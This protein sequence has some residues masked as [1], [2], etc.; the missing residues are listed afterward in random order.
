ME[1]V[2]A[3][4]KDWLSQGILAVLGYQETFGLLLPLT[5][6]LPGSTP[7]RLQWIEEVMKKVMAVGR[8]RGYRDEDHSRQKG[9][10]GDA[11]STTGVLRKFKS[12]SPGLH[13]LGTVPVLS[14]RRKGCTRGRLCPF[15]LSCSPFCGTSADPG[16]AQP[17]HPPS[18]SLPPFSF[19]S[20][21][22]FFCFK[23][24][25]HCSHYSI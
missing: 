18:H 2:G 10:L 17:H 9:V 25:V 19:P 3:L 21:C 7:P 4:N 6:V 1:G 23:A 12:Q 20:F 14:S 11:L 22:G 5:L 24:S 16:T 15:P 13:M 8:G